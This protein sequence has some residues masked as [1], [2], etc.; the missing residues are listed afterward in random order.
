MPT[1]PNFPDDLADQHHHWHNPSAHPEAGPGRTHPAG[2]P[3]GGLEFLVFHRNFNAQVMAWYNAT[4]F[5]QAPF[6]DAAQKAA[7]VTPWTAVPP[8]LQADGDWSFWAADAARLDSG[9]PDF[10]SADDLGTFIEVGIHNNFLHGAAANAF[11]E[12]VVQTLHSPQST[13]FYKIHGLVDHWW[14]T[15][16][17]RHKLRLKELMKEV[18]RDLDLKRTVPE[19]KRFEDEVIKDRIEEVKRLGRDVKIAALE[20]FDDPRQVIDPVAQAV[21]EPMADRLARIEER[22]FPNRVT[23]IAPGERPDVGDIVAKGRKKADHTH[24]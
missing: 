14:S 15:W 18:M 10:A 3:G 2:T 11:G 21:T 16:Q 23:F 4:A 24:E 13:L 7:L 22:I 12:P 8:E 1:I 6:T 19:V 17:R 9:T 5:T 20:A